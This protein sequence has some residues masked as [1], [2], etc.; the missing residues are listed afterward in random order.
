MQKNLMTDPWPGNTLLQPWS[1]DLPPAEEVDKL[2]ILQPDGMDALVQID[3]VDDRKEIL[4]LFQKLSKHE[5]IGFLTWAMSLANRLR[6][7]GNVV[8]V[9]VTNNTGEAAES[10]LDLCGLIVQWGVPRDVVLRELEQCVRRK[11]F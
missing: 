4:N 6:P 3:N 9:E 1:W 2:K 8:R 11:M 5:R 10:Y 7:D